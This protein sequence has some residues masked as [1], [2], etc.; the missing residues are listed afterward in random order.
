MHWT[1]P[2]T[3]PCTNSLDST[4]TDGITGY[5]GPYGSASATS[6]HPGGVNLCFAD[7][8][9]HFIKNSIALQTWWGLGTRAGG[10]VI[11]SDQ[12]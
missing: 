6:L 8:S 11:S 10:E 1:A 7:G 4:L 9:V 5:V 12:Y 2:N 3:P